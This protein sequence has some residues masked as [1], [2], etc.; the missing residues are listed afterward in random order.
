MLIIPYDNPTGQLYSEEMMLEIAKLCVKYN[1]WLL[2]DEAYR[3]LFYDEDRKIISI[4]GITDDQVPG[5]EGRRLS[6]ESTSKVFNACG[7]RIGAV[8][9]DNKEYHEKSAAEY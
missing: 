3:G 6:L 4:W 2:S 8:I 9:T 1:M 5:I 7:L